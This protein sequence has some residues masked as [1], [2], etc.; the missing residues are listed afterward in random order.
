MNLALFYCYTLQKHLEWGKNISNWDLPNTALTWSKFIA[1]RVN[2]PTTPIQN[3]L[4]KKEKKFYTPD[5][6]TGSLLQNWYSCVMFHKRL[7]PYGVS[8]ISPDIQGN[9]NIN[10][11]SAR[12][13]SVSCSTN[14]NVTVSKTLSLCYEH[15]H[16][17]P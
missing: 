15:N 14:I 12:A 6:V 4:E 2:T 10:F 9:A 7:L 1:R 17:Q 5:I 16:Y 8:K 13:G 3:E 11:L